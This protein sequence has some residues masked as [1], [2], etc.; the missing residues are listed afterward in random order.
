MLVLI[1]LPKSVWGLKVSSF[2]IVICAIM[3]GLG[4]S[5]SGGILS[6]NWVLCALADFAKQVVVCFSI[7]GEVGGRA[8]RDMSGKTKR[9]DRVL[10]RLSSVQQCC[11]ETLLEMGFEG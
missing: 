4:P 9:V 10:A 11:V 6:Q 3:V 2:S 1:L 5:L 8:R 7:G